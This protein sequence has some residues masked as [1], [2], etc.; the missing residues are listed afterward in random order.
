MNIIKTHY[1]LK[2]LNNLK[3]KFFKIE[4]DLDD[5]E[6]SIKSESFSDL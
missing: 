2:Q 1:F 5:F 3:K 4:G 6:S